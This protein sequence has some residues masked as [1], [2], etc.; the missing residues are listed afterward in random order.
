MDRPR[1]HFV[2][3]HVDRPLDLPPAAEMDD[4]AEIA[5]SIGA[6][7]RFGTGEFPEP[8]DQLRGVGESR[9]IG[10]MDM[11]TQP[12]PRSFLCL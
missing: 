1:H 9:A 4:V 5:A 2:A 7:R 10:H 11:V 3:K 6:L 12:T 8:V